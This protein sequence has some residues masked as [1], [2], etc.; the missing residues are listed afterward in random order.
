MQYIDTATAASILGVAERTVRRYA[1]DGVYG[2]VEY[3]DGPGGNSGKVMR[4]PV[5]GLPPEA[6]I[7]Y[8]R[9]VFSRDAVVKIPLDQFPE[10]YRKLAAEK[11]QVLDLWSEFISGLEKQGITK[12]EATK[13]Y[14]DT[15]NRAHP[16]RQ[17]SLA[18]LYRWQAAYRENGVAGL[19]PGY[20]GRDYSDTIPDWAWEMF[21]DAYLDDAKRSIAVCYAIVELEA[22]SRGEMIPSMSAFK[23]KIKKDMDYQVMVYW[24]EG[25]KAFD[26]KCTPYIIR[27]YNTLVSNQL[28][29]SDHH[30]LDVACLG[31]KKRVVFPW[32]T[33]W[34][35]MKSRR[36]VGYTISEGPNTDTILASFGRAVRRYG[37]PCELLMDNGRDYTAKDFAGRGH[38]VKV[39]IDEGRVTPLVKH[40]GIIPHFAIPE[41]AKA[42][43]IERFFLT[44]KEQFSK[45]Y[46]S[47]RGGNIQERPE[48]LEDVVKNTDKLP[49]IFDIDRDFGEWIDNIYNENPHEGLGGR[50][51]REVFDE[52]LNVKRTAPEDVL[53]L[54][55]MRTSKPLKVQRNGI[56]L[57]ERWYYSTELAPHQG[58]KVFARYDIKQ[59]GLIYVFDLEDRF[60]CEARNKEALAWGATSEDIRNAMK[61]KKAVRQRARAY[62]EDVS[63]VLKEPDPL[64]RIIE[65]RKKENP[66]TKPDPKII[67]IVRNPEFEKAARGIAEQKS[68]VAASG[69]YDAPSMILWGQ[70]KKEV[71]DKQLEEDF[72]MVLQ[73]GRKQYKERYWR[74]V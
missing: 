20:G 11:I 40:L 9:Q 34:M 41:N 43:P 31:S 50:K 21:K 53:R 33:G 60:L 42:K 6:Q 52:F 36:I 64:K 61:E 7:E 18:T 32:V 22:K 57:F 72:E 62:K 4:I 56:W 19:I 48:S 8:Y 51:P 14:V 45:W 15:Y 29:V 25:K 58:K 44:S 65:L 66:E 35:D 55:M 3:I 17:I 10:K 24:R 23:R 2:K 63:K 13:S 16:D 71:D 38:R 39:E 67:E 49:T 5:A 73:I 59:I 27:D 47:Y 1:L 37:I 54:L 46:E 30:Q 12:T 69:G 28:W 70:R 74:D 26:D 68:Q